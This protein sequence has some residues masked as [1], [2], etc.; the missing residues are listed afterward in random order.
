MLRYCG[1]KDKVRVNYQFKGRGKKTWTANSGPVDV[2][3]TYVPTVWGKN[4]SFTFD[5]MQITTYDFTCDAPSNVPRDAGSNLEIWLISCGF[6]DW[7]SV[8]SYST[9]YGIV[10]GYNGP[11]IKIGS[12]L[13]VSGNVVNVYKTACYASV[14]LEWRL[15]Q[16][17]NC[18]ITIKNDNGGVFEEKGPCPCTYNVSCGNECPPGQTKVDQPGYPGYCCIDCKALAAQMQSINAQVNY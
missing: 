9:G 7:G 6:D 16:K 14:S 15:V 3:I 1:K 8:G 12:G 11:P 5:G 17:D 10:V 13:S 4:F 18:K 2:S